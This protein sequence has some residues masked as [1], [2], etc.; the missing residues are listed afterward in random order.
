M[1]SEEFLDISATRGGAEA[2][3]KGRGLKYL[4]IMGGS[5]RKE[6]LHLLASLGMVGDGWMAGWLDGRIAG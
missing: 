4:P 6:V 3:T 2:E 1:V 5:Y